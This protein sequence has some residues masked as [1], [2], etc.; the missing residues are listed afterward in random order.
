MKLSSA[1]QPNKL[2]VSVNTNWAEA[3]S[4]RTVAASSVSLQTK[5]FR[6]STYG[7][8]FGNAARKNISDERR[9]SS[10]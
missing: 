1:F 2:A 8:F 4:V 9:T 6:N 3:R 7:G 5:F 10:S